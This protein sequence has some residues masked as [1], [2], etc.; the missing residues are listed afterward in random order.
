MYSTSTVQVNIYVHMKDN[1]VSTWIDEHIY[2]I[3]NTSLFNFFDP[4]DEKEKGVKG[5]DKKRNLG[6][7]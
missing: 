3:Y 4:K 6:N 5:I 7:G 1:T 2:L